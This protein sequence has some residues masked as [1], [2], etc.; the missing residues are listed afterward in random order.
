MAT[1]SRKQNTPTE[2]QASGERSA[3]VTSEKSL[4]D[5]LLEIKEWIGLGLAIVVAIF[6]SGGWILTYFAKK[7][8]VEILSCTMDV[9]VRLA[10]DTSSIQLIRERQIQL[11]KEFRD[12]RQGGKGVKHQEAVS[13][14]DGDE[15]ATL[16][17]IKA[18]IKTTKENLKTLSDDASFFVTS[19]ARKECDSKEGRDKL[20][21]KLRT[22]PPLRE[23]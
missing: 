15:H 3:M 4:L 7:E 1:T 20:R 17:E 16:E 22:D 10:K 13:A 14:N 5:K 8:E 12:A 18:A 9:N 21:D 19:L 23:D 11:K 2:P 6:S